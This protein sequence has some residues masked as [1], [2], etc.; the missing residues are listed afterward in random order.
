[1]TGAIVNFA[2]GVAVHVGDCLRVLPTLALDPART[3]VVTDPPWPEAPADLL[4]RWSVTDCA[5]VLESTFGECARLARRLVVVLGCQTDPRCLR[6]P[7]SMPFVRVCWLR[8]AL[9]S[10]RGTVLNGSDVAYVFGS[11]EAGKGNVLLPGEVTAHTPRAKEGAGADAHPTPR[12]EEHMRWLVSHFTRPGDT[13]LDPFAGSGTILLAARDAG[14]YSIG[15]ER[16]EPYIDAMR[17][18]FAQGTL[19]AVGAPQ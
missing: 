12:R 17:A 8:L 16:H 11:R 1:M 2:D 10:Y 9:P 3:V 18:R 4:A 7:A 14:R 5:A 6:I 13:V 15:I 19:L